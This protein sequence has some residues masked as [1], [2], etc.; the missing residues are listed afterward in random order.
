MIFIDYIIIMLKT[1]SFFAVITPTIIFG[2][3]AERATLSSFILITLLWSTLVYDII[4]Y[5]TWNLNG[6]LHVLGSL[7]FAG[8]GPVHIASGFSSLA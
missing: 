7:D 6:W 5:W 2:S 8:G 1:L 4:A 3:V